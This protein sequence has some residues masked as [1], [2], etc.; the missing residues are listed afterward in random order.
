MAL[1]DFNIFGQENPWNEEVDE[2]N[3]MRTLPTTESAKNPFS[4]DNLTDPYPRT[5][6]VSGPGRDPT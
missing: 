4:T 6:P 1:P 5:F 3:E 2:M